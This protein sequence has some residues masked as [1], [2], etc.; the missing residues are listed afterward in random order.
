MKTLIAI[1]VAMLSATL[2]AMAQREDNVWIY[3]E[4]RI[5]FSTTPPT[6]TPTACKYRT[7]DNITS[8]AD[9]DGNLV[10]WLNG[11]SLY[12]SNDEVIY[13][14][15][16]GDAAVFM[17]G[18]SIVPFPWMDDVYLFVYP[19]IVREMMVVS[20]AD[21]R[22]DL[23]HPKI[24]EGYKMFPY[25]VNNH[26]GVPLFFQK[27]GS[28]DFWLLYS[29]NHSIKVYA[30]TEDGFSYTGDEYVLPNVDN[31][32]YYIDG[33]EMTPDRSKI[34]ATTS[35]NMSLFIDL[36]TQTGKIKNINPIKNM[37]MEVFAFSSGNKY[38][39][40]SIR[41]SMCRIP[42]EK[43]GVI[44]GNKDFL[45]H[46]EYVG[47]LGCRIG[48]LK[49]LTAG[50]LYFLNL[51]DGNYLGTVENCDSEHPVIN[52]KWLKLAKNANEHSVS[53]FYAFPKTYCYPFGFV[54]DEKCGGEVYFRFSD[55][56]CVSIH[57][58][59]GD[60]SEAIALGQSVEHIYTSNGKYTVRL[61]AN[62]SDDRPQQTVE[63]TVVVRNILTKLEIVEE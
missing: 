51:D 22:E 31:S 5:D 40:Y 45:E 9:H 58:D 53:R 62:Y 49:F 17:Y 39:Y 15:P 10:Y 25:S 32:S 4:N 14:L 6:V 21:G 54:A 59:F 61:T 16:G 43:L 23:L 50:G 48:D 56:D 41:E 1:L 7:K 28:R 8:V 2:C 12:N 37:T 19:D 47:T 30:L 44:S 26:D 55:V 46:S 36:D 38:F 13:S 11:T 35:I 18:L 20:V 60:G 57:W 33:C 52:N 3:A 29:Y 24:T 34:L 63:R 27:Y 42:V